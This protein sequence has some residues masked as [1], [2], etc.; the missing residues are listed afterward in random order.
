MNTSKLRL[1]GSLLLALSFSLVQ[2]CTNT[3]D[4]QVVAAFQDTPFNDWFNNLLSQI[5]SDH[6]YKHMPID[7]TEQSEKFLILLHDTYRHKITKKEF[8]QR[9]SNQYPGHDYEISF[10]TSRLP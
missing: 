4:P 2:G 3:T 7:T 10:I 9:M 8:S 1:I 6:V 5:K